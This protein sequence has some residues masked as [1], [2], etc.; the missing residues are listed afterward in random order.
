MVGYQWDH[1]G[2]QRGQYLNYIE[3][4]LALLYCYLPDAVSVF[5]EISVLHQDTGIVVVVHLHFSATM[6]R[7][8]ATH[9]ADR[10]SAAALR[11]GVAGAKPGPPTWSA[12]RR[13]SCCL[14]PGVSCVTDA[15]RWFPAVWCARST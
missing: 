10:A 15:K 13:G 4:Y 11:T 9:C 7:G 5:F 12:D 14:P 3:L 8:G 2:A 6:L 1:R